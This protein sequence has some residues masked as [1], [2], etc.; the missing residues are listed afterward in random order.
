MTLYRAKFGTALENFSLA[1]FRGKLGEFP[2]WPIVL[3][4]GDDKVFRHA[5]TR[6]RWKYIYMYMY[7]FSNE[8]SPNLVFT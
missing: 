7:I 1:V 6:A 8:T 4:Y 5:G 2:T 3:Y